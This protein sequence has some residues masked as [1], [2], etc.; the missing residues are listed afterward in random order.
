METRTLS[1]VYRLV[2]EVARELPA[3]SRRIGDR[4]IVLTFL[5]AAIMHKPVSWACRR[6]N[7]PAWVLRRMPVVPSST[8]M[9]RRLQRASVRAMLFA[10]LGRAQGILPRSLVLMLDGKPLTVGGNSGDRQARIGRACGLFARGYR[11]HLL[12]EITGRVVDWRVAPM[13]VSEQAM[14]ERLARDL[15]KDH[16][17]YLLADAGYD[18]NKVHGLARLAGVQMISPRRR[19][20]TGLGKGKSAHNAGRVRSLALTEGPSSFGRELLRERARIERWLGAWSTSVLGTL[21][22]HVRTQR[23]VERWI[24][25]K[26]ILNAIRL[27]ELH[28]SKQ[29]A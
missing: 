28:R 2:N 26:L 19:P 22:T 16:Y 7:W 11:V 12:L 3:G 5:Y 9:S 21:P 15:P 18:S 6:S 1:L 17:A 14:A 13:H 27:A 20:G 23:R 8:T 10:T 24:L 29:A 4:W 25:A